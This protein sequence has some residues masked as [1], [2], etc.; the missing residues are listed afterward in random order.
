MDSINRNQPEE[1]RRDLGGADAIKR[2][3]DMTDDAESCFFVTAAATGE[4]NGVRPMS[5]RKS[6]DAGNLWFLSASDSH[7]NQELASNPALKL[8][9]QIGAHSGFLELEGKAEVSQDRSKIKELWNPLLK[10]WFTEGEDDPRITVIRFVP[11]T[12]YYWDNKHGDVVAGVK[13]AVGAVLGKTL[14]DS[15]EGR[16][17]F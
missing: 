6:D 14:D 16:L 12:G 5:V 10:T 13:V 17:T 8:Y 1:N 7:K 4:T 9:F 3:K 2:V 11:Q 15:I